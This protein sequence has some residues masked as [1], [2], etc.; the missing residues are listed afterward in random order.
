MFCTTVEAG[1]MKTGRNSTK[2]KIENTVIVNC[3]HVRALLFLKRETCIVNQKRIDA[4]KIEFF[5]SQRPRVHDVHNMY[6][7]TVGCT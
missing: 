2:K 1:M 7:Y 3:G 4:V 5:F 6:L